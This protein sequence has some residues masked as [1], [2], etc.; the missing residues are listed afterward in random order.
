MTQT[1][2]EVLE[3]CALN[4]RV[5]LM[6][7]RWNDLYK[8]LPAT[9]RVGVGY[10]PAAPLILAAWWEASDEQKKGRFETHIRWA[11][12]HSALDTI[13]DF[14]RSLPENEWHHAGE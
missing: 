14:L 11:H 9:R 5:C 12:R 4:Q 8:M 3:F 1:L 2:D 7:M 10:E 13:A 6:P